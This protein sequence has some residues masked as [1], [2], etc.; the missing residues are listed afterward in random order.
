VCGQPLVDEN[1]PVLKVVG[2][3][4]NIAVAI[5]PFDE[6]CLRAAPHLSDQPACVNHDRAPPFRAENPVAKENTFN[7]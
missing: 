5:V 1:A 7:L 2:E 3:F 6:V 4:D